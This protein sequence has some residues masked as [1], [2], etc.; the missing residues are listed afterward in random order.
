MNNLN[1]QEIADR[2]GWLAAFAE[3]SFQSREDRDRLL[4]IGD[5]D[6][7][8]LI[9]ELQKAREE[10]AAL[11]SVPDYW[12]AVF[13]DD[14]YTPAVLRNVKHMHPTTVKDVFERVKGTDVADVIVG[15]I[16]SCQIANNRAEV[17]CNEMHA[18]RQALSPAPVGSPPTSGGGEP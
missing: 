11:M 16:F 7:P 2:A 17:F 6:I 9:S 1:L 13:G 5:R 4:D 18:A 14:S 8:L 15:L 12:R 3:T 10:N